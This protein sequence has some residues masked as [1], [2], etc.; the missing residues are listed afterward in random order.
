M[1]SRSSSLATSAIASSSVCDITFPLGLPEAE[2][3]KAAQ[4]GSEA[5]QAQ[6]LFDGLSPQ[7]FA[8]ATFICDAVRR[9]YDLKISVENPDALRTVE[10]YT[11]LSAIDRHVA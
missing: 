3:L 11:M 4:S 1:T 10:R 9:S 5:P 7:Q 2:I 8:V 6:S